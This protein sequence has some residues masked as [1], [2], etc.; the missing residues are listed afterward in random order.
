MQY[1]YYVLEQYR[2]EQETSHMTS[3]RMTYAQNV[4][5]K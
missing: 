1:I 3:S 4:Y 2:V 5:T